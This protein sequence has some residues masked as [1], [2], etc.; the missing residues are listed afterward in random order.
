MALPAGCKH[1]HTDTNSS[2]SSCVPLSLSVSPPDVLERLAQ[3][4]DTLR[5]LGVEAAWMSG[6]KDLILF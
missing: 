2:L 3:H 1:T 4:S 6:G 5:V